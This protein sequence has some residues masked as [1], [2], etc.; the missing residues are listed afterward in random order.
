MCAFEFRYTHG[1]SSNVGR[2][3][4]P[5]HRAETTHR[6][7]ASS[8]LVHEMM[9]LG[10]MNQDPGNKSQCLAHVMQTLRSQTR[11]WSHYFTSKIRGSKPC[12]VSP[13]QV[14]VIE[15]K[16]PEIKT[17]RGQSPVWEHDLTTTNLKSKPCRVKHPPVDRWD[18]ASSSRRDDCWAIIETIALGE[19]RQASLSSDPKPIPCAGTLFELEIFEVQTLRS[20]TAPVKR[21]VD[22]KS[23]WMVN[24]APAVIGL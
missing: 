19:I 8:D 24:C 2:H 5:R 14:H 16:N 9:A 12:G 17:F 21:A 18:K 7:P 3:S 1:S 4:G 6:L 22:G 11:G 23:F 13:Q 20:R 10:Y 15:L